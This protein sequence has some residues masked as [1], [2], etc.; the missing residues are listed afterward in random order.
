MTAGG[1]RRSPRR[2]RP[3][4]LDHLDVLDAG[5]A[6]RLA[7]RA[8]ACGWTI[9][10]SSIPGTEFTIWLAMPRA[11]KPAPT[12]ATRTGSPASARARRARVDDDHVRAARAGLERRP[13]ASFSE[14]DAH[15]HRPRDPERRVVVAQAR[16]RARARRTRSPGRPPRCR[17]RAS[18][19][20]G[21]TSRART[22]RGGSRARQLDPEVRQVGGRVRRACRRSR[23]R[24]RRA[25]SARASPRRRA[26]LVVHAA[27]RAGAVV[28]R[29][30]A[31]RDDGLEA[32]LRELARAEG[33]R[34]EPAL[35]LAPLEVDHERPARGSR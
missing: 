12:I 7:A 14:I 17:R 20:R 16:A 11:M 21:R 5:L 13:G 29:E 31:L 4:S 3:T 2:A 10:T 34:E 35:V 1:R 19:S 25:C 32:V 6:V 24:S 18:G 8:S 15:R 26:E 28:E 22:A 30:V 23:R 33:P 27:Q 9:A